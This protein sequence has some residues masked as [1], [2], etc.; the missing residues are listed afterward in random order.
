LLGATLVSQQIPELL[1]TQMP[2]PFTGAIMLT[3]FVEQAM[4]AQLLLGALLKLQ[5]VPASSEL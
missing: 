3:P 1:D 5:F 4:S 2:P